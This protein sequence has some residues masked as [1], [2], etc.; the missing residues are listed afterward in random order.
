MKI[1][2]PAPL[3]A[4]LLEALRL[5]VLAILPILLASVNLQTGAIHLNFT[6]IGATAFVT[7]LRF[8]DKWIHEIGSENG[9]DTLTGGL[10][11]F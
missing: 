3:K 4:A 7:V 5:V 10:T 2:I 6:L 9:N 1:T 11:R 8:I